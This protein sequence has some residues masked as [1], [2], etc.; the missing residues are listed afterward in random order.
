MPENCE[1]SYVFWEQ[2]FGPLQEL[3]ALFK[4]ESFLQASKCA[5]KWKI[6]AWRPLRV[7]ISLEHILFL[8]SPVLPSLFLDLNSYVYYFIQLVCLRIFTFD[9]YF[10]FFLLLFHFLVL[11]GVEPRAFEH[12]GQP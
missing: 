8:S 12:I 9:F 6:K 1:L 5:F 7:S 4:T 2:N 11:W 3:S 10:A